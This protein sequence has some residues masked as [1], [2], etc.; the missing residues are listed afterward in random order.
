ME[1]V[2]DKKSPTDALV[3]VKIKE[4]DYKN[5]VE[6]KIRE[7]GK[8]V[9]LKGFRPGKVPHGLIRKMYGR[10]ILADEVNNLVS[11]SVSKYIRE[12]NLN[13]IGRPLPSTDAPLFDPEANRDFDFLFDV[14]FIPEFELPSLSA[15]K[16][17]RYKIQAD[18][19]TVNETIENLKKRHAKSVKK[20]AVEEGD[21]VQGLLRSVSETD[22]FEKQV[23]LPLARIREEQ[24]KSFLGLTAGQKAEFDIQQL[25]ESTKDLSMGLGVSEEQAAGLSGMFELEVTEISGTELPEENQEFFDKVFGKDGVTDASAFRAK[26]AEDVNK[27]LEEEGEKFL[28]A[29]IEKFFVE[30]TPVR[31]SETFLKRWL[32]IVNEGKLTE[33]LLGEEMDRIVKSVKWSAVKSKLVSEYGLAVSGEEIEEY[34]RAKYRSMMKS[35]G[36]AEPSE[37]MVSNFA[38]EFLRKNRGENY[39]STYEEM[40]QAKLFNAVKEKADVREETISLKDFSEKVKKL[41]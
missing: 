40:I 12:Q 10:D 29:E 18:E 26:V 35:W 25:F 2:F 4:E 21:Y 24:R 39:E 30:N 11:E 33:E 23:F 22:A 28:H 6:E 13:I 19:S 14:G 27:S 37:E 15:A 8:K 34:T 7:Y 36:I 38:T 9:N 17:V 32:L 5:S 1:I 3:T 20:E 41:N 31:I 16:F